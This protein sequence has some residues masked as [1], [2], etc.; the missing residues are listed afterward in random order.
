MQPKFTPG[1]WDAVLDNDP[2]G[3]PSCMYRG[4]IAMVERGDRTLAVVLGS[5]HQY[6][7]VPQEQWEPNARAIAALPDLVTA[8]HRAKMQVEAQKPTRASVETLRI[9]NAALAKA[10]GRNVE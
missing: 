8:L 1:P 3:Q 4:L 2:R 9:I 7:N 6:E 10:E 5:G